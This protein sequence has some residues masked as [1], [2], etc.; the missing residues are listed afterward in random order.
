LRDP[1]EA[2][3]AVAGIGNIRFFGS[4]TLSGGIMLRKLLPLLLL[5][6]LLGSAAD[7]LAGAGEPAMVHMKNG[8]VLRGEVVRMKKGVLHFRTSYAGTLNIQW[9]EV[10][11]LESTVPLDVY[12]KDRSQVRG[13]AVAD[14]AD[15]VAVQGKD[16]STWHNLDM[17]RIAAINTPYHEWEV[18]GGASLGMNNQS[19]NTNKA[20]VAIQ[21]MVALKKNKNR[22]KLSGDFNWGE[23]GGSRNAYNWRLEPGYDRYLTERLFINAN[24]QFKHDE[25]QDLDLR[26]SA[27]G[28]VGYDLFAGERLNLTLQAG[29]AHVWEDYNQR[30]DRDFTAGQWKVD[31]SWWVYKK[32]VQVF[33]SQD[34]FLSLENLDEY[35]W[36]TRSG[37]RFPVTDN[38]YTS[39]QYNYDWNNKPAD[40]KLRW[41]EKIMMTIGYSFD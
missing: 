15:H 30:E 27:G 28:G 12:L 40:G 34:G 11:G 17:E 3:Q 8:D 1:A 10:S 4:E 37:L 31:F 16:N 13:R 41:D 20:N 33:H 14:T 29:P 2:L 7:A 5:A 36:Q 38:L 21:G 32:Y 39:L 26:S 19:G 18:K 6:V 25:F 24:T 9:D 35:I 22:Y 23:D